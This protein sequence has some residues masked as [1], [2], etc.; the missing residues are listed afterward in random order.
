[1]SVKPIPEGYHSITPAMVVNGADRA[2]E[3]YK[4]AFDAEE[5]VRFPGPDGKIMHAE[6]RIGD[7]LVMLGE[8]ARDP[9][10]NLQAMLYVQ[11]SDAVFQRAVDAGPTVVAPM[12][13]MPWG[14]RGGRVRDPFGNVWF[15]A[16]HKEDVE[17]DEML[18]RM[19]IKKPG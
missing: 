4:N 11:D 7:S 18:R 1:M 14:D 2:I 17:V 13:D 16:T 3:F 6:L 19:G 12:A 15:I 8:A 10:A 9:V 5:K